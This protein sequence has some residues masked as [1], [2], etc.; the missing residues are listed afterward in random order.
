MSDGAENTELVI[1]SPVVREEVDS[2]TQELLSLWRGPV[3]LAR[4]VAAAPVA[5]S[6]AEVRADGDDPV[7]AIVAGARGVPTVRVTRVPPTRADSQWAMNGG[8]LVVWPASNAAGV[9]PARANPDTNGGIV[10]SRAV[11]VAQFDRRLPAGSGRENVRWADGESAATERALGKGCVRDVAIPVDQVGD[12]ALR[13]SFRAIAAE[14]IEPCGGAPDLRPADLKLS[15]GR[16]SASAFSTPADVGALPLWLALLAIAV[17]LAEQA[18]RMRTR[19][20]P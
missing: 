14:L 16:A 5:A 7:R 1:V 20:A 2:A 3:R 8:A 12:V 13:P 10:S 9:L 19:A 6:G 4:V 15:G 18:L 11:T 17:L